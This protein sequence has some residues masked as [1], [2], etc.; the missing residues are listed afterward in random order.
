M[1]LTAGGE[2]YVMGSYCEL[3]LGGSRICE[4]SEPKRNMSKDGMSNKVHKGYAVG[5]ENT[6]IPGNPLPNSIGIKILVGSN[7]PLKLIARRKRI[8]C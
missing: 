7:E 8:C 3:A 2:Q 5:V 4:P 6:L 1:R